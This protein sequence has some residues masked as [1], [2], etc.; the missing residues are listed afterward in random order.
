MNNAQRYVDDGIQYLDSWY[1]RDN[2]LPKIDLD[3]LNLGEV[4]SC[5]AGQITGSYTKF[6]DI[7]KMDN[8]QCSLLGLTKID[9]SVSYSDLSKEWK[10]RITEMRAINVEENNPNQAAI[11]L[12]KEMSKQELITNY[13]EKERID[14]VIEGL[15]NMDTD[16]SA[17]VKLEQLRALLA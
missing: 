14:V 15:E 8:V 12:L 5:I 16:N 11:N 13:Y 3:T 17:A 10:R 2:W 1:G 7:H 4:F 6:Q 9:D